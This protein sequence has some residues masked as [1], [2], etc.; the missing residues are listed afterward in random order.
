MKRK[1]TVPV[2]YLYR[3]FAD[4]RNSFNGLALLI[5]SETELELGSGNCL[6]YTNKQRDKFK[7]LYWDQTGYKLSGTHTV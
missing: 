1:M 6:S 7:V 5:E 4:F 3:E 2:A